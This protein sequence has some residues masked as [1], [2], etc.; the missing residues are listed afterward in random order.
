MITLGEMDFGPPHILPMM[1]I[2]SQPRG[3]R[4]PVDRG[5]ISGPMSPGYLTGEYLHF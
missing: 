2:L 1:E 4:T 5:A 3:G